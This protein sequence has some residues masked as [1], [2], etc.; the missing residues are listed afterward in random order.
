MPLAMLLLPLIVSL[1]APASSDSEPRGKRPDLPT[2]EWTQTNPE[3][4]WGRRAGLQ[5]VERKKSFY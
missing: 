4:P 1:L 3:A 2:W 5:V